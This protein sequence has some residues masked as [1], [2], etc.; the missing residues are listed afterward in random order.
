MRTNWNLESFKIQANI[1]HNNKY[2][3]DKFI[4]INA[5]SKGIINCPIHGEFLQ[6]LTSHVTNKH[7]CFKCGNRLKGNKFK[8]LTKKFVVRSSRIHNNLYNYDKFIYVKNHIKSIIICSIHGEFLQSPAKHI[9][10]HGCSKCARAIL[11]KQHKKPIKEFLQEAQTIHGDKYSYP[12]L[13]YNNNRD[14]ILIH[15]NICNTDFTQKISNHINNKNGCQNCAYNQLRE[16][17]NG[18]DHIVWEAKSKT[19]KKFT[20]YK[21]YIVKCWNQEEV[22]YK[23]GKTY[24][25]IKTR[26]AG[27]QMPYEYEMIK[28]FTDEAKTI[29]ELERSLQK[30]NKEFKYVPKLEFHGMYECYSKV[31]Y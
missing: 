25:D 16:F 29:S 26:F 9:L 15:C 4:Y 20:G 24:R 2:S 11:A 27:Y 21:V 19:S 6:N 1:V 10:G 5:G 7:G 18:Y 8:K 14:K 12:N 17:G 3:Y 30:D 28:V 22:F 31:I 13:N 23:I